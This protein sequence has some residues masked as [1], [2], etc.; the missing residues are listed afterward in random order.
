MS[1]PDGCIS[2]LLYRKM[3][4][5]RPVDTV[6]VDDLEITLNITWLK[7]PLRNVQCF[8]VDS[9]DLMQETFNVFSQYFNQIYREIAP[10]CSVPNSKQGFRHCSLPRVV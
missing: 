8:Y 3:Y 7:F 1:I 6:H 2:V 5:L 10:L 4:F 9:N